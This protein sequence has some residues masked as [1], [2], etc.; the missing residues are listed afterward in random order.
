VDVVHTRS[1]E[2]YARFA[3]GLQLLSEDKFTEAREAF[4]AALGFDPAALQ[5]ERV[6]RYAPAFGLEDWFKEHGGTP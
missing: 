6:V 2:A 1:W 4:V 3:R 5:T